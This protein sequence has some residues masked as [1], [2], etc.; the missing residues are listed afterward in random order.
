MSTRLVV[1]ALLLALAPGCARTVPPARPAA[2]LYRDLERLVSLSATA[3][4]KIDRVEVEALLPDALLSVCRVEPA[5]REALMAWLDQQIAARGGPVEAAWAHRGKDLDRVAGLLQLTRI[6]M[7]LAR[8][9]A[10]APADCP[11]WL[12]PDPRFAGRQIEDDR[13]Q[14]ALGGGGKAI[15]VSQGGRQDIYFGGAGRVLFGRA[16]GSRWSLLGGVEVGASASFPRDDDGGRSNLVLGV[17][18][19]APLVVR[20]RLVSSYFEGEVGYL[21]RLTEDDHDPVPGVHVGVA[22]GGRASRR[23]WFFPGAVFGVGYERTFPGAGEEP[24]TTLKLGFRVA[25]DIDW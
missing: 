7:T 6:R 20:Y 16:V 19:V 18:V 9:V 25:F 23:R 13:W 24:L 15:L 14:L 17:D 3:G 1:S 4:W 22:F 2:A 21:A 11:F 5:Q 8:A 10:A 12:E